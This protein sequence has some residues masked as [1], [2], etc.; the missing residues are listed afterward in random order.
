M[1]IVLERLKASKTRFY[2]IEELLATEEVFT[3]RSRLQTLSIEK[4]SMEKLVQ[5]FETFLQTQKDLKDAKTV[6]EDTSDS[7]MKSLANE[8]ISLLETSLIQLEN[9][10]R[11]AILPKDVNDSKNVIMEIRAGTGGDEAAL[12]AGDL[13]R[14]YSRYA[15]NNGW[16]VDIIDASPTGTG[17]FKEVVFGVKGSG[18]F[19]RLKHESGGHRVQRVPTTETSGRIHTSAATVAVLPEAEEV[20][21]DVDPNELRID[22]F[23]SGGHGGQNVQKVATA[24]RITHIPTGI[25]ST[26]QDER[27]Q[28][29]NKDRAMGVLR[30]RLLDRAISKQ[31]EQTA[32]SRKSQVGSGDRSEKIRTYNFPQN[33]VTDH[34]IG[35]TNHNLDK[36]LLG[37]LDGF[38][39]EMLQQEQADKLNIT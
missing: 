8:E 31:H 30:S 25:V 29:K 18:A 3:D 10:L 22:I 34:R 23:H 4:S 32:Q 33:R 13:Y 21:I 26:C 27:S 7:E 16:L 37:D 19:S 36:I 38:I 20:E 17:G 15:Q 5:L 2:E 39:D 28:L 1:V 9:E 35:I 6:V 24:V 12:F 14:M 11:L